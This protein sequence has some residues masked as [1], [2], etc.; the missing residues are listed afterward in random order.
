MMYFGVTTGFRSGGY[1][2]LFFSNTPTYEP[3]DLTAYEI[4]YKTQWLD[5]RLQ[6]NGSFYYYDYE[7]IHT[8]G[9]EVT[10]FGGTTTSVL[11]APGAE[12]YGIEAEATWLATDRITLGGNFSWTPSEYSEDFFI[13]DPSGVGAP[14]SVFPGQDERLT[15]IKGNQLLQVP[16][17]KATAWASYRIPLQGGASLDLFGVYSW[18]SE[19]YYSPFEKETEKADAY[20]RVDLRATLTSG[21]GNWIV[22][23]FV[24]NVFDDVGVLQV[25]R[26]SEDEF[27]RHTA[28]TTVPRHYGLELT[29]Q[30]GRY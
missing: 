13:S 10:S 28:G 24:N 15:N 29:F 9:A 22:S 12:I 4:G 25:L 7:N 30:T 16:E 5:D 17:G 21:G 1:N 14:E 6:V 8:V 3:E 19:V 18:I 26:E 23:A 27:F 2:L 11:A 20:D